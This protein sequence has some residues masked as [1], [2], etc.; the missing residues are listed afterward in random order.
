MELLMRGPTSPFFLFLL[1]VVT[2]TCSDALTRASLLRM[3]LSALQ[4]QH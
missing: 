2:P 4:R 3:T 1:A